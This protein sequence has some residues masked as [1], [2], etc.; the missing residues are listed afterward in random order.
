MR[1][2]RIEPDAVVVRTNRRK[3]IGKKAK[4]RK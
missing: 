3:R 2:K 4:A 1:E